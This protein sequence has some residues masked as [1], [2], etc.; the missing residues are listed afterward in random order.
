MGI[1]KFEPEAAEAIRTDGKGGDQPL[2]SGNH[3]TQFDSVSR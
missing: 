3:F 2:R 1:N